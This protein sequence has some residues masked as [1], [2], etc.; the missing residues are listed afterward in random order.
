[1]ELPNEIWLEIIKSPK[2][3]FF[4]KRL[5]T[6]SKELQ[7]MCNKIIDMIKK[8]GNKIVIRKN[9]CEMLVIGKA[10]RMGFP[11]FQS[12]EWRGS[13]DQIERYNDNHK[14]GLPLL[15]QLVSQCSTI[16]TDIDTAYHCVGPMY[17]S[18]VRYFEFYQRLSGNVEA[19]T[20]YAVELLLG[21]LRRLMSEKK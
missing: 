10:D 4:V 14:P 21:K 7:T 5:S 13:I 16:F 3:L 17:A 1:M 8:D 2:D 9:E 12:K 6:V 11:N 19:S 15:S 18:Y 20:T